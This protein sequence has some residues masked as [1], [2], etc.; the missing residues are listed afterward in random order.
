MFNKFLNYPLIFFN[1]LKPLY[2]I[3]IF[4]TYLYIYYGFR[5]YILLF[6]NLFII[7]KNKQIINI[8]LY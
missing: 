3:L 8:I 6:L 5:N 7:K 1:L 4:V 2:I